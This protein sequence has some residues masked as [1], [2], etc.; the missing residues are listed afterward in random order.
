M[1]R[2]KI[3]LIGG[4]NIGGVLA[5]QAAYRELGDVV[6]FDVVED[7]PQGK[8]L[9]IAEGAP[10]MAADA[11]ITGTNT[12]KDI[13]GADV[14]IVTAGLPRKPGM[15]RDDLLTT[16]VNIIKNVAAGVKEKDHE[17]TRARSCRCRHHHPDR[18]RHGKPRRPRRL[19]H[20]AG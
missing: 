19:L 5:E 9:D 7:L 2:N 20:R 15:T 10:L 1:A 18:D 13:A 4:G 12:Y 16:N 8:T 6:M 17:T 14:V 3:A 11:K